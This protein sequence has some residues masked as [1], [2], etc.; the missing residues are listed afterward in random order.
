[1]RTVARSSGADI[2]FFT[3]DE[4]VKV[5]P[6]VSE[7]QRLYLIVHDPLPIVDLLKAGIPIQSV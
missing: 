6:N 4:F 2:R 3:V 5:F 1:M 7:N